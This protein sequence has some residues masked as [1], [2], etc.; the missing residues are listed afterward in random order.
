MQQ[1]TPA[2]SPTNAETPPSTI[3]PGTPLKTDD[4]GQFALG[5]PTNATVA[6]GTPQDSVDGHGQLTGESGETPPES[7]V[8][9]DSGIESKFLQGNKLFHLCI[10]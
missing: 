1:L 7:H 5:S 9:L 6:P 4:V 2:G 10:E 8:V 3:V